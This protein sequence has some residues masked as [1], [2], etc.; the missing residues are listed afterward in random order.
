[1]SAGGACARWADVKN[2]HRKEEGGQL[3]P[4]GAPRRLRSVLAQHV[5]DALQ[6]RAHDGRR[7]VAVY[8][9]RVPA[10]CTQ[11]RI[12]MIDH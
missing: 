7:V 3:Q 10:L 5:L 4:C 1:M 6:G 2:M 8:E 12:H 11:S 9:P